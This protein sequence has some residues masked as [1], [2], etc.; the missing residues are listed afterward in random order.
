M[1][2][3]LPLKKIENGEG[4]YH[5]PHQQYIWPS[6]FIEEAYMVTLGFSIFWFYFAKHVSLI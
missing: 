2:W 5:Y 4:A 3:Y 1:E 6:D